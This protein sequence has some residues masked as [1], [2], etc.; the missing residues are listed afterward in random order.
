MTGSFN[1]YVAY[2]NALP[3]YDIELSLWNGRNSK[4]GPTF[5]DDIQFIVGDVNSD[6][7]ITAAD[8]LMLKKIILG[9]LNSD[10]L[11]DPE[12]ALFRCDVTGDGKINTSDYLKLKRTLL[13]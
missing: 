11:V 12:T 13:A 2:A 5:T 7:D 1:T 10:R 8:Y 9:T 4:N 3:S 6:F